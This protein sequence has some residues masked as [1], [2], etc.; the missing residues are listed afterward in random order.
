MRGRSFVI[1]DVIHL[2]APA[3]ADALLAPL[4]ALDPVMDTVG[5]IAARDLGH[6]HMDP[7]HPVPAVG[8]GLILSSLP[9]DAIDQLITVARSGTG[10]PLPVAELR[11]LGGEMRRARPHN[12][13]LAA[14]D[15]HY[16]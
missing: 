14:I 8:D 6:L 3:G 10:S 15:A 5:V 16:L 7:E 1:I 12:G 2:G 11:H 13:A 4:R 9:A